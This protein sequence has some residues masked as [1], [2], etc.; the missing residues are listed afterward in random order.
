MI[1]VPSTETSAGSPPLTVLFSFLSRADSTSLDR[2]SRADGHVLDVDG[3]VIAD[4][5]TNSAANAF[6]PD[7]NLNYEKWGEYWRKVHGVRFLHPDEAGDQKTIDRLLRYDQIHRLAPGP[8][9]L[10]PPPY[11]PPLDADGKLFNTVIGHIEPY[12]R[13][14][15]DGVAYLNFANLDDLGAVLGAERVRRKILPEDKAIFRDLAPVLSR[16][17]VIVPNSSGVDSIVLVKTHHRRDELDRKTFQ[18]LWLQDHAGA[19]VE[20]PDVRRLVK[21][22]VQL[23]NIGPETEGHSFF[24]PATSRIDGVTMLAFASARDVETFLQSDSYTAIEQAE[25]AIAS[26]EAGEYW[27]GVVFNVV[28]QLAPEQATEK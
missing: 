19:V 14:Q 9:S 25:R 28:D 17:Y 11:R 8:T 1:S 27:M 26:V 2:R 23:H 13:P 22:Y 15:W 6:E 24:H 4:P 5:A 16:Q 18:R 3:K 10:N 12:H 20:Q 7:S 21:R